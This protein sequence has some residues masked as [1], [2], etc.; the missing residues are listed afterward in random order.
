MKKKYILA[1]AIGAI[2]LVLGRSL[3]NYVHQRGV[4]V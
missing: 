2:P 4:P 3:F 1:A